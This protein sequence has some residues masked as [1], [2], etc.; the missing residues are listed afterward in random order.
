MTL[1]REAKNKMGF[2][3][4][5]TKV[6]E[7]HLNRL[8]DKIEN[9][10]VMLDQAIRDRTK[11]LQ[12]A[13]KSVISVMANAKKTEKEFLEAQH[14]HSEWERKAKI[15]LTGGNE[16]LATKALVRS[17]EFASNTATLQPILEQQQRDVDLLKVDIRKME[18][19]L[20][21]F[22]RKKDVILAQYKTA[23]IK[24]NISQARA[25]INSN[26]TDSLIDRIQEKAET[27]SLEASSAEELAELEGDSLDKEF[28]DLEKQSIS[29]SV[30]DKLARLKAEI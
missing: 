16:D 11:Q 6:G 15:A 17:E 10:E 1:S 30:Q 13:K 8:A 18:N 9:P 4:R 7:A 3:S 22:K 29:S 24:K 23:E 27:A 28:A 20:N 5:V 2:L 26:D 12:E 19:D 21:E 14:Q 25:K